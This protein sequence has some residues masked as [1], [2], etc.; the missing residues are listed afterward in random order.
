MVV[1]TSDMLTE[2][3]I[4]TCKTNRKQVEERR[5]TYGTGYGFKTTYGTL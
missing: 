2:M 1:T 4:E 5:T 3:E